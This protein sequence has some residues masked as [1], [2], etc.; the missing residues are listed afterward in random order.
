MSKTEHAPS[1]GGVQVITRAA[2]IL[3]TLRSAPGGITQTELVERIGLARSTVHRL[4]GALEDEGLVESSGPRGRYRIGP[5]VKRMADNAWKGLLAEIHPLLEELSRGVF[6]TVDLSVFD[7]NRVTFIDQVVAPHRL[8]AVSAVGES[9]PLHCTA[10][11][12]AFLAALPDRELATVLPKELPAHS[13]HTITDLTKLEDE[14]RRVRDEG[15]AYDREEHTEGVCAVSTLIQR[16]LGLPLAVSIP[17]PAQRFQ[18]RE[19]L[20]RD[21]LLGWSARVQEQLDERG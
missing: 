4:L 15:V 20:L 8:Q 13:R 18:R 14:L 2:E 7:R 17:L 5:V 19:H 16:S 21:A 1:V 10:N 12:K 11:G 9:F 6:E 3:R